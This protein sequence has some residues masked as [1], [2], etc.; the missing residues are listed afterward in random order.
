MPLSFLIFI[1]PFPMEFTSLAFLTTKR[2]HRTTESSTRLN[3]DLVT[4]HPPMTVA[5]QKSSRSKQ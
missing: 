1:F 4:N 3:V 5:C 2:D